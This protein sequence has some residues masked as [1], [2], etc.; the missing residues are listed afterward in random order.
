M[1]PVLFRGKMKT[2]FLLT[3]ILLSAACVPSPKVG[4]TTSGR[5]NK[6]S[7]IYWTTAN[8]LEL[9]ISEDFS[10][11]EVNNITAMSTAWAASVG[12]KRIFFSHTNTT[13]EKSKA[14]L[15]LDSLGDD[16]TFGIYRITHWPASLPS[17]ALA[18]TQLFLR[19][20]NV[21]ESDEYAVIEHADILINENLY[22]FRT[23]DTHVSGTFDLR[24]VVLHEMGHFLGLQ[25]K[26]GD[27]VMIDAIGEN[28]EKRAPTN[29]DIADI[30]DKYNISL[31]SGGAH[32][33]MAKSA[34]TYQPRTQGPKVKM[35]IELRA[36]GKCVH[37]ING[38]E[39]DHH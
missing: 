23:T 11:A 27:T 33:I 5:M 38:I 25:H 32:A 22:N 24:T 31:G 36:D 26:T 20:Y 12:N 8:T 37:S 15:N 1:K 30:A 17:S 28:S 14:N 34:Q 18:V 4:E 19:P 21:G 10:P 29:I 16:D 2:A 6:N 35:I 3:T 39:T 7:P 9:K 13:E